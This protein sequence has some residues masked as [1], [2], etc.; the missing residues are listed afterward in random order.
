MI[1][2]SLLMDIDPEILEETPIEEEPV[3]FSSLYDDNTSTG[4]MLVGLALIV[5]LFLQLASIFYNY[6]KKEKVFSKLKVLALTFLLFGGISSIHSIYW[7]IQLFFYKSNEFPDMITIFIVNCF[8]IIGINLCESIF[9]DKYSSGNLFKSYWIC[10]HIWIVI[11][12]IMAFFYFEIS[13]FLNISI[14][15]FIFGLHFGFMIVSYILF[16]EVA[17]RVFK[18][19]NVSTI[20]TV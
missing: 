4:I 13:N 16:M 5:T 19:L 15:K 12:V 6:R 3:I 17:K 9:R 1:F 8:I 14:L 7:L 10:S 2:Q 11:S 18:K 20:Y